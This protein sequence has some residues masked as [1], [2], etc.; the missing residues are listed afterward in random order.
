MPV[1]FALCRMPVTFVL[2]SDT[3]R[4]AQLEYRVSLSAWMCRS[5][6]VCVMH[7]RSSAKDP[8]LRVSVTSVF[9]ACWFVFWGL[10]SWRHAWLYLVPPNCIHLSSGSV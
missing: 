5:F 3:W 8:L 6:K 1:A 9:E 2:L 7:K 10:V 4:A